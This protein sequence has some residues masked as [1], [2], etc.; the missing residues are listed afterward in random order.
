MPVFLDVLSVRQ[1]PIELSSMPCSPHW[2]VMT[3]HTRRIAHSLVCLLAMAYF[4][5]HKEGTLA[6]KLEILIGPH[7]HV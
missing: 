4:I 3:A 6:G 5:N 7:S 1:L 2:V